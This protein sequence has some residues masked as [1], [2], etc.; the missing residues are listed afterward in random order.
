MVL[1]GKFNNQINPQIDTLQFLEFYG[2]YNLPLD[3]LPDSIKEIKIGGWEF[4][5]PINKLPQLLLYL[6][7]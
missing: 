2:E 4:N 1:G 6:I 7:F 5:Q 3:N